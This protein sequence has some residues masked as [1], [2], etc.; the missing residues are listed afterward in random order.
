MC[1]I[2]SQQQQKLS[3]NQIQINWKTDG[4][5]TDYFDN[6]VRR[7]SKSHDIKDNDKLYCYRICPLVLKLKIDLF[8]YY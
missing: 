4:R 5:D 6:T 3:S 2:Q 7:H 8:I 1:Y